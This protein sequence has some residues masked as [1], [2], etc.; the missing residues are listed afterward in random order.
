MNVKTFSIFLSMILFATMG[1]G[2]KIDST[3]KSQ[4]ILIDGNGDDWADIPLQYQEDMNVVYGLVN[5]DDVIVFMIRFNDQQ[6]DICKI[7][8]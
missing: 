4:N 1:C 8:Q 3:W 5:N 2:E 7:G 6:L